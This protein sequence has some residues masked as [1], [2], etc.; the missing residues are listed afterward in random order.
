M[1]LA[2]KHPTSLVSRHP[3]SLIAHPTSLIPHRICLI[4]P[5]IFLLALGTL[6]AAPAALRAQAVPDAAAAAAVRQQYLSDLDSLQAKFVALAEAIPAEKYSWRPMAGV[7][8][9]GE[10]FK[11]VASEYYTYA[12]ASVGAERS[13]LIPRTREGFK[14]FEAS[15]SKEES[16][17]QL[18]DG[19]AFAKQSI[20]AL[21]PAAL[22][23]TKKIF[24][25]D[26]TIIETT[27]AVTDDLHEHLGQLIAYS[28]M[29]GVVPP[30]SR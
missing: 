21:D 30:W 10:V 11:H 28:R 29:L 16:L 5:R 20:G 26:H 2:S 22:A 3:T 12:P 7:R 17:K 23:G 13:P 1:S 9:V 8:T 19:F 14:A 6:L 25:S 15:S 18:R 27:S 4:P 24:G